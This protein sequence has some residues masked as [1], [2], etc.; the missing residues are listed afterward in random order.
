MFAYIFVFSVSCVLE[1]TILY[2]LLY[3][4]ANVP[5]SALLLWAEPSPLLVNLI[6]LLKRPYEGMQTSL[7]RD[8]SYTEL[9]KD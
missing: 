5:W 9:R 8:T 4:S 2:G 1:A 3:P 6:S 7:A